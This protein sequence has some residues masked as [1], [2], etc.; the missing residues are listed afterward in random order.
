MIEAELPDGTILE[1]P[2]NTPDSVVDSVVRKHLG[3]QAEPTQREWSDVPA[4]A[5]SNVPESAMRLGESLYE[6]VTH[7]VETMDAITKIGAGA[8]QLILPESIVNAIGKDEQSIEMA[9]KVGQFMVDRY[10]SE[11]AVKETL[12]TDPVGAAADVASVLTGTGAGLK[13]AGL[14]KTGTA[15]S[16]AGAAIEPV[17]A[18]VKGASAVG[19]KIF[20]TSGKVAT[21]VFGSTTGVGQDAIAEAY[22]VG[23][24]G[25]AKGKAFRDAIRGKLDPLDVVEEAKQALQNLQRNAAQAYKADM[26]AVKADKAQLSFDAIDA[27]IATNMDKFGKFKGVVRNESAVEALQNIQ[28][29]VNEW[30]AGN[31]ADFHTPYGLDQLKQA[32]WGVVEQYSPTGKQA[33]QTARMAAHNIYNSVKD[34]IKKQA[35]IYEK[36]MSEYAKAQDEINAITKELSL[37]KN[38]LEDTSL[39]KLLSVMR[40]NVNT[41]FGSRKKRVGVLEE[42]GAETIMPKIAGTEMQAVAPRGIQRAT[43]ALGAGGAYTQ[44]GVLGAL[45]AAAASS[46]RL[47]GETAHLLGRTAGAT[48]KAAKP[49]VNILQTI[50]QPELLNLI[51]QQERALQEQQK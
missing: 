35:P 27:S 29:K 17:T 37:G 34:T 26:K 2:D 20:G 33:N 45:G 46:P 4:E 42:A 49:A 51:Y 50:G 24:E 43:A 40:D 47:V 8:L 7:P 12:A 22:R 19:G 38:V 18:A 32:I 21:A 25:G 23:A 31:P 15:V 5:I 13:A 10:G 6:A 28:S 9:R 48:S 39:R 44:G 14:T 36:T 30:K 16:K 1:F 3:V 41:N 11:E